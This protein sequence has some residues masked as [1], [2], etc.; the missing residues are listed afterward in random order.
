MTLGILRLMRRVPV[1]SD[2]DGHTTFFLS[3]ADEAAVPA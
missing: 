1:W 3:T 2:P